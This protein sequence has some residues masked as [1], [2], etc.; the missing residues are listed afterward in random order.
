M[1]ETTLHH[2]STLRQLLPDSKISVE[3]EKPGRDGLTDLASAAD[4][5][6]YSRTWAEVQSCPRPGSNTHEADV[7]HRRAAV[8]HPPKIA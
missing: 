4:V 8:T 2:I 6:F 5:V 7:L 1:P 3:I